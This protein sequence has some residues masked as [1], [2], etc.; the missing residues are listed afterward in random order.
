VLSELRRGGMERVVVHLAGTLAER[1]VEPLVVCLQNKGPLAE[2]LK[3]RGIRVRALKSLRGYDIAAVV[4]L[5]R[6]LRQFRPDVINIHDRS[7]LPYAFIANRLAG[8][9]PM[10]FSCHGL[11]LQDESAARKRDRMATRDVRGVTAVSEQAGSEYARMLNWRGP[12]DIVP[13]GVLLSPQ[14]DELTRTSQR[15]TLGVTPDTFVFLAVGNVKPEKGYEDLLEAVA[16]LRRR[17]CDRPFQVLVAGDRSADTYSD[18]LAASMSRLNLDGTV[19]FLGYRSDTAALYSAADAFVL[20]SRKEGLP[21]VLLE[22][23]AAGLPVVATRVGAVPEVV[24]D[25]SHGLLV[26]VAIPSE[27]AEAM[28]RLLSDGPLGN[29]LG[30]KARSHIREHYSAERMTEGYLDVFE[31]AAASPAG[32]PPSEKAAQDLARPRV[33]MLGP[34]PPL[35][36]GM[37]TVTEN[38][39]SSDLRRICQ[40]AVMNNGKSTPPRR[41]LLTGVK[42]QTKLLRQLA[43]TVRRERTCIVHIHT[44]QFFGFWRDCMHLFVAQWLGG[45][46]VLHNHGASFDRWADQMGPLARSI[47]RR[48]FESAAGVIVLSNDWLHKLAPLAPRARWHV[49]PNGLPLPPKVNNVATDPPVFLFLG[50]W[51]SRK[52]VH[53]LVKAVALASRSDFP[54]TVHLAGFEKEPGQLKELEQHIAAT[55]CGSRIR[56]LGTLAPDAKEVAVASAHCLVLPSYAEGLPMAILEGMAHGLPVIATRVGA[57]PEV[58]HDG[59]EGF[60]IEPGDVEAL[61]DRLLRIAADPQLRLTMGAAARRCVEAE[62]SLD[63]MVERIMAIYSEVLRGPERQ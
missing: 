28:S 36:G 3:S 1:G 20:S 6:V 48:S 43:G 11:L 4:R 8:R 14:R 33:L 26:N 54:G 12:V 62:Y 41:S 45:R 21:M 23:M 18:S 15:A 13:N 35:T 38:L 24:Q 60:L 9:K 16:L 34:L 46:V 29:R 53:D 22:A 30:E 40:L 51:T 58:V 10:V 52:G 19:R 31:R 17:Y 32:P 42:A 44:S 59:H 2:E 63:V 39:R 50:D 55:G 56:I 61:A 47:M 37:A 7:S 57:I 49:V 27:L 25:G 5:A